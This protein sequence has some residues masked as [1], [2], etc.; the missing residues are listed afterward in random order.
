[1]QKQ[2]NFIKKI[3]IEDLKKKKYHQIITRF[4][5][6]PNGF[7]HLGHARAIFINFELA[8]F[9]NGQTNLRY[10]DTNPIK[11]DK[12]YVNSIL[13]DIKWL[14]YEPNKI[15]FA[16]D[17]FLEMYERALILIKKNKAFV[18]DLSSK[19]IFQTRGNLIEPGQNSPYRNRSIEENLR[20]F[21]KMQ[22]G[23][24]KEGEKVLR[25]KIDMKSPNINLRDPVLYRILNAKT[26][27]N[28]NWFIFPTYDYAHPLEDAIEKISHSLCSL[29]FEDH[30]VLYD[31]VIKETEMSHIPTQIEF[32]KLN[33]TDFILGKRNLKFLVDNKLVN[34]WSDPRIPTLSGLRRKGYTPDSIKNFLLNIGLSKNNSKVKKSMLESFVRDD[35]QSKTFKMMAVINPLKVTI[36]NYPLNQKEILEFQENN[37]YLFQTKKIFF[38]REIYIE[39]EDFQINKPDIKYKRLF[40]NGEVRLLHAYFIKVYD[41][42]KNNHG[43][44]IELLATYDPKTKSGSGFN[45]RK[46]NGTIHFVE[47]STAQ[48]ANFNF[49]TSIYK[50]EKPKDLKSEFNFKSLEIK[51]GFLDSSFKNF[52]HL[53]KFQFIRNGYFV[54][55]KVEEKILNFNEIISLKKT[56]K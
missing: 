25:A 22:Q 26:L 24:Y 56:Y 28:V 36:T 7:L 15:L 50:T 42:I 43:E 16:S 33:I 19:E 1:M 3:M 49:F 46:P 14:G 8:K 41:I 48:K 6:E 38:S 32:G 37:G 35:L 10:D 11:E 39:K 27:K 9:F 52:K 31:W 4:P 30:R 29:E 12:I 51:V 18:D 44:I 45:E 40:L 54:F 2:S 21:Q 34:G 13:E 5:P 47:V 17:Y 20:L 23:I 55:D 53:D